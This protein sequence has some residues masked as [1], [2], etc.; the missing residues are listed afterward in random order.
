MLNTHHIQA[1]TNIVF[2]HIKVVTK[3]GRMVN[4]GIDERRRV[5]TNNLNPQKDKW[6]PFTM[7]KRDFDIA[8]LDK[9]DE[10]E[11]CF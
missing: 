3:Q 8:I 5:I 1:N 2:A 7:T 10:M 9:Y 4:I 11:R 6:V